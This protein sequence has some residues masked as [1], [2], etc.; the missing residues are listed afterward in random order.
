MSEEDEMRQEENERR[1]LRR[2]NKMFQQFCED[3]SRVSD[4]LVHF[5]IPYR[6]I[7]FSGIYNRN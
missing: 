7:S 5:E 6:D 4:G 3:A 1:N 2:M